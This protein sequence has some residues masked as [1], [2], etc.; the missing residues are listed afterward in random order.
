V[1]DKHEFHGRGR[2]RAKTKDTKAIPPGIMCAACQKVA[3][4]SSRNAR[5]AARILFQ[6]RR[7]RIYACKPGFW[8]LTS[9]TTLKTTAYREFERGNGNS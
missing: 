5:K 7:M 9:Y 6:G 3:Y 2:N 4:T 1:N 8:H